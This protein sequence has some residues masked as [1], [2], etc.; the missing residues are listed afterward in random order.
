MDDPWLDLMVAWGK[1]VRSGITRQGFVG[2]PKKRIREEKESLV[3]GIK[4]LLACF[5]CGSQSSIYRLCVG[6]YIYKRIYK[7]I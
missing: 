7:C 2:L 4:H 5:K 6:V 3:D 1:A